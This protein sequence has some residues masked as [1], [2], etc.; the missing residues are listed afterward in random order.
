MHLQKI[1]ISGFKSFYKKTVIILPKPQ[2]GKQGVTSVVG[3]NGSGKSNISDA[4]KW[5]LG[6]QSKKG[7]R[8]KKGQDVIFA[9]SNKR[10]PLTSASVSLYFDNRDKKI[11][12]DY[13]QIVLTRKIFASG[14]NEYFINN[15]RV[16]LKEILS[17]LN[18]AGIGQESYSIVDQG[19]ADRLIMVGPLERKSIIEEAARVKHFQVKKETALKRLEQSQLKLEKVDA[20]LKEI[21]P[22][23]K[24][25]K[26]QADKKT[27]QKQTEIE[28]R[29]V[30][31][32][33]F[34]TLWNKLVKEKQSYLDAK[35]PF[36]KELKKVEQLLSEIREKFEQTSKT[37]LEARPAD[38]LPQKLDQIRKEAGEIY[39]KMGVLEGQ[40]EIGH[41]KIKHL[42]AMS[43]ERV[44][45]SYIKKGL[46]SILDSI[47]KI[48]EKKEVTEKKFLNLKQA[49]EKLKA[50][51][52]AGVI[53][54]D[55]SKEKQTLEKAITLD[56][57]KQ[58]KLQEELKKLQTAEAALKQEIAKK[59]Q[60]AAEREKQFY[61]LEKE[62]EKQN[63][64][65]D[66]LRDRLNELEIELAKIEVREQDL[67]LEIK[68]SLKTEPEKLNYKGPAATNLSALSHQVDNLTRQLNICESINDSV[69]AEFEETS[70]R[71]EF[72][73]KESTDVKK[74]IESLKK[75]IAELTVKIETRFDKTFTQ[76]AQDFSKY[77]KII[78]RGGE[79]GLKKVELI[80]NGKDDEINQTKETGIDIKAVPPGKKIKNLNMLSGGEKALTSLAFLFALI[81]SS[82]PPFVMLDEVD[83]ALDEAN[84]ARFARIIKLLTDKTQF[85]L[86][87]H[88]QEVMNQAQLL[89]GVTMGPDGASNLL[90]LD[91]EKSS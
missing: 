46:N 33:Y 4:L 30:S 42:E 63:L 69:V 51:A 60:A 41:Q 74:T 87:T 75:M 84:S 48:I 79:A 44:D 91:L 11:S 50:E 21:K 70:Q 83:A 86:V 82:S 13:P 31:L 9:G 53:K 58:A 65:R 56:K 49:L 47:K 23:L 12:L 39:R 8:S 15:S 62:L 32:K 16:K 73:A 3:P 77:F 36:G 81:R 37:K 72:L 18:Q 17:I 28:L 78:F 68:Q 26:I 10:K 22:R 20:L 54:K 35:E 55:I 59:N 38:D 85:I 24:Y 6:G 7:F 80:T 52:E 25:L 88:N 27:K 64:K 57:E 45:L 40:I 61:E 66:Q 90:S 2:K 14:E 89:Y 43:E 76:I 34:G 1:E 67:R 29:E 19:M 5:G 71:F